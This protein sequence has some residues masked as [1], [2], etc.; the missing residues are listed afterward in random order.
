[1]YG[2]RVRLFFVIKRR[3]PGDRRRVSTLGEELVREVK[4][5]AG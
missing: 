2:N 5:R 4:E 3:T 1:M